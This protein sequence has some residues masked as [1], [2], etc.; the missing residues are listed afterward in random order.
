[1]RIAHVAQSRENACDPVR[2]IEFQ[3]GIYL[4]RPSKQTRFR[5]QENVVMREPSF[6]SRNL[7]KLLLPA[8]LIAS[9]SLMSR[10]DQSITRAGGLPGQDGEGVA[11]FNLAPVQRDNCVTA[12]QERAIRRK[13]AEYQARTKAAGAGAQGA[14]QLFPFYPQAGSLWQDLCVVNYVDL[15]PGSG[16]KDWDCTEYTYDGHNGSDSAIR[17]FREQEIGVP[18]FAALDG[19]VIDTHDGEPDMNTSWEGQPANY[20]AIGHGGG[21]TTLYLHMKRGSVAV[22]TGQMVK[23]GTQLGLTG[24]SG[25]STGPHLHFGAYLNGQ[26]FEPHAGPCRAGESNWIRQ[27]P[28]RRDLYLRDLSFSDA[29]LINASFNDLYLEKAPRRGAFSTG[30]QVVSFV[31]HP[32]NLPVNSPWRVRYIRPNGSV[33]LDRSG[34]LSN[35]V[36]YRLAIYY[37]WYT[38]NLDVTGAWRLQL[39]LNNQTVADA[40][41]QVVAS[42]DQITNQPPNAITAAL[43]PPAP[44]AGQVVFC[45]VNTPLLFKDPNYDLVR[46]RYQWRVNGAV[47]RDVTSAALSDA[48][49]KDLARNGDQLTCEVTPSDGQLSGPAATATARYGVSA[50][51]SASA[52]NYDGA[53][54]AVESIVAAFGNGLATTT[55][56][57]SSTPLPTNL[58]G[59]FVNVRDNA[60]VERLAPLFLVSPGQI[61][62]QMPPGTA[63]GPATVTA[64][65]GDGNVSEGTS[66]ITAVAPGLFTVD[67]SGKGLPAASVL[68]VK[69]D[70][71]QIY[72]PIVQLDQA[73]NKFIPIPIDFGAETDQVFLILYGTGVRYHNN[74]SAVTV[75]VGGINAQ[76]YYAGAQDYFVGI[77]QINALLP[78]ALAGRGE[79]DL[80]LK[81]NNSAAN[82][83]KVVF[84]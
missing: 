52:A 31:I 18:I 4:F 66:Q 83:V 43:D 10:S 26:S 76:V 67:A 72:E 13:I 69:A 54:L 36:L 7:P 70:N 75:T 12:E 58:A 8:L 14:P 74:L 34:Q 33:A 15:D 79:V 19:E 40:P 35:S 63:I 62:F 16:I 45:R 81:A 49:T 46:Y 59:T 6:L 51:A 29:S 5:N 50:L 2:L 78:R 17:T 28:I 55:Q 44:Q 80:E 47:V 25:N 56:L 38:V 23:A 57:A 41:F 82:T 3:V 32:S 22:Q 1:L 37:W 64:V 48:I 24:S 65:S 60:G 21:Q 39:E 27:T 30:S 77:D 84:K 68:R 61:N 9:A 71:S 11:G 73:T 42:A 53:R 20:V